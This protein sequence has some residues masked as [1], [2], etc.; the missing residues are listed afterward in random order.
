MVKPNNPK[1]RG[2]E[3]RVVDEQNEQ[4][5]IM[6]F[7][8]ALKRA[9]EAGL[10]L[11]LVADNAAPPVCRI[12]NYGKFQYQQSKKQRDQK[13]RQGIQKLK[14]IKFHANTGDHDYRTKVNHIVDFLKKGHRVKVS[15][16]FRGREMVHREF[17]QELMAQVAT[18][19]AEHGHVEMRPRMA[20]RNLIMQLAPQSSK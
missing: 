7:E 16:W 13:K 9:S 4:L 3:I 14:E 18:D 6:R 1:L 8:D 12:M 2:A 10:D 19:V 5:G 20:G 15:L 17:G 11:V